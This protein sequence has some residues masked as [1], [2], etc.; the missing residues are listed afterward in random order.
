MVTVVVVVVVWGCG[1]DDSATARNGKDHGLSG[2][3]RRQRVATIVG[4]L[5]QHSPSKP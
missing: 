1:G 3:E 4:V 2:D 5:Q